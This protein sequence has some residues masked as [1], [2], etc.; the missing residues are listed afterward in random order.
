MVVRKKILEA[1]EDGDKVAMSSRLKR[2]REAIRQLPE[3]E[4]AN[5]QNEDTKSETGGE[6]TSTVKKVTKKA[7]A[8][9]AVK[10]ASKKTPAK[11]TNGADAGTTLATIC[12]PMKLEPRRAR[13][14]LR[15]ADGVPE[16]GARWTWTK[17]ADVAK[18]KSI[19][20]AATKE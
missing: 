15:T 16:A 17:A 8:K 6:S 12:K 9:K 2:V 18:V 13:R 4:G 1:G 7:P 5:M 14:I 20:T 11:T 19:L 10:K 3:D